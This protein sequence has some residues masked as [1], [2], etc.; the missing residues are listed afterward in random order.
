MPAI[1]FPDSAG[2][3]LPLCKGHGQEFIFRT[4]ADLLWFAAS[5]GFHLVRIQG[6]QL[7]TKSTFVDTPNPINLE[8]FDNRGLYGNILMMALSQIN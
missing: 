2:L 6:R 8:V 5:Y 7:P 3:L 1:R 4:Y